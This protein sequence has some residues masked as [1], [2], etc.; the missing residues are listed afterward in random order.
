MVPEGLKVTFNI[1]DFKGF[2][3]VFGGATV[4]SL[5]KNPQVCFPPP[6]PV[7]QSPASYG[8]ARI[9]HRA[10]TTTN[11]GYDST[12]GSGTWVYLLGKGVLT[13]HTDLSPRVIF[14]Y[15]S[16]DTISSDQS[17]HGTAVAGVIAGTIHGVAEKTSIIAV[18]VLDANGSGATSGVIACTNW[19]V[20]DIVS[21][22]RVGEA[23][24]VMP[25]GGPCSAAMSNAVEQAVQI[26]HRQ[27]QATPPPA[28]APNAI[29]LASLASTSDIRSSFSNYG[30]AVGF[31]APGENV[32]TCWIGSDTATNTLSGTTF[33][34]T[35]GAGVGVHL[36]ALQNFASPVALAARMNDYR[37]AAG[38]GE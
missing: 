37:V 24:I 27:T 6:R 26:V 28:P 31:F 10:R 5:R 16:V 36:M 7:T 30:P 3:G 11:Y 17:G 1:G 13:T 18:K 35:Y 19:S 29:V 32:L 23:T 21:K 14:G 15:N 22:G 20:N 2:W 8:L 9:S 12:A 38:D 33:S 25:L 4:K 34:M